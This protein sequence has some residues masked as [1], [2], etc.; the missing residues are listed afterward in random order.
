MIQIDK[1]TFTWGKEK[2]KEQNNPEELNNSN[3]NIINTN[4]NNKKENKIIEDKEKDKDKEDLSQE[5]KN[6]DKEPLI[7]K[8]E[9]DEIINVKGDI[10]NKKYGK[11]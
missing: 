3:N 7:P 11:V 1:G 8:N 5:I 9:Q 2:Q 10:K 6:I 4:I